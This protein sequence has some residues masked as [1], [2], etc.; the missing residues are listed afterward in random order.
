MSSYIQSLQ[1]RDGD[2]I[3]PVT[4]GDAVFIQ[5]TEG[6]TIKQTKL[7]DKLTE[8]ETSF[9]AG[10]NTIVAA[11]TELGVTPEATTPEGIAAAIKQM[12]S[13]R[14][15]TGVEQG[16][17]DVIADP[18][19]YGL[20]TQD[21]YDQYGVNQYQAG[22]TYADGRVN[23]NSASYTEGHSV[24]ITDGIISLNKSVNVSMPTRQGSRDGGKT[25]ADVKVSGTA[26]ATIA[27]GK[28]SISATANA[29]GTASHWVDGG[30]EDVTTTSASTGNSNSVNLT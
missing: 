7:S 26:S 12:Y 15:N 25:Q 19:S 9:T 29:T 3:Y 14:Y 17:K 22:I 13:D 5:E 11:L 8:M 28:L 4:C 18:G 16:H 23:T 10:C 30:L 6:S 2:D 21:E 1:N 27:N 20:I 24:G